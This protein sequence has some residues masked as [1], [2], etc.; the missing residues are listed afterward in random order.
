MYNL[1]VTYTEGQW[2][3]GAYEFRSDRVIKIGTDQDLRDRYA[4]LDEAAVAELLSYPSLFVYEDG[5]GD[6]VR[7]GWLTRIKP[8]DYEARIEFE[9]EDALPPLTRDS[10]KALKTE[11]DLRGEL[12]TTHWAV[13]DIDLIPALI[14]AGLISEEDIERQPPDSRLRRLGMTKAVTQLHIRPSVFRVPPVKPEPDLV[15]AM[16][17]FDMTFDAVYDAIASACGAA[18]RRCQRADR[19]WDEP[20]V[21]QDVFSL[22]YRSRVVICDFTGRNPNV[23][24]EAGIAHTLGKTVIPIVQNKNDVPFDLGHIRYMSTPIEF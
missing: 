2:D 9:I 23:F 18:D 21:I 16:M 10:I 1:F 15:S 13:K 12:S 20:E 22:I 3:K 6:E 14:K 17:P 8:R 7:I 5:R 11:L 24:Y 19:V 4:T